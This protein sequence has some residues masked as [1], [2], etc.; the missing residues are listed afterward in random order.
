MR[1]GRS[2]GTSARLLRRLR[3]RLAS[4]SAACSSPRRTS[5]ACPRRSRSRC[6]ANARTLHELYADAGMMTPFFLAPEPALLGPGRLG[7][8]RAPAQAYVIVNTSSR[9]NSRSRP[10]T[11]RCARALAIGGG[12]GR[13][14]RSGDGAR[15]LWP[16]ERHRTPIRDD[17]RTLQQRPRSHRSNRPTCG[18]SSPMASGSAAMVRRW[19]ATRLGVPEASVAT[20]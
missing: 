4:S 5:P 14:P 18:R 6:K 1:S 17:R 15:G 11:H 13:H 12:E 16:A 20:K 19:E 2:S 10:H 9:R 7:R 3:R 8:T